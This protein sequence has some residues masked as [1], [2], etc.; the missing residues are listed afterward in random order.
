MLEN[1]LNLI[2]QYPIP[3]VIIVIIVIAIIK[4]ITKK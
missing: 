3:S 1:I 2:M 4:G